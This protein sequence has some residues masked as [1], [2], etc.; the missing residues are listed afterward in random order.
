[1][2]QELTDSFFPWKTALHT[3]RKQT[4]QIFTLLGSAYNEETDRADLYVAALGENASVKAN[5]LCAYLRDRELRAETDL[6]GRSLK[7]QMKYANKISA[8][9]T[10]IIGDG[11]LE[12]GKAQLRNM[13]NGEQTEIVID[14]FASLYEIIK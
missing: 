9:Y 1:M 8:K 11:E 10:L 13:D 5:G 7:A 6:V 3:T 2:L 12:N 14:D 4:E